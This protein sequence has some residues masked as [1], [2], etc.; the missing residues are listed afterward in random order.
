MGADIHMHTEVKR[1]GKWEYHGE[2]PYTDRNYDL[3]AIL[4][5]VRNGRGF[6]GCKT[7]E[8]FIPLADPKGLPDDVSDEVKVEAEQMGGDGHSH[9]YFTL[10]EL[11]DPQPECGY[12]GHGRGRGAYWKLTTKKMGWMQESEYLAWVESGRK[13]PTSYCGGAYGGNILSLPEESYIERTKILKASKKE[14]PLY[15]GS[16]HKE[17]VEALLAGRKPPKCDIY[18]SGLW[19]VTY[20]YAAGNFYTKCM[21]ALAKLGKPEDVRIVFFFDN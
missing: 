7:G 2:G 19:E 3:F 12:V 1:N 11:Q 16:K 18:V 9:S 17:L 10:E 20:Q 21:P 5:D 15:I 6:A 8:G 13:P 4:A 14:L